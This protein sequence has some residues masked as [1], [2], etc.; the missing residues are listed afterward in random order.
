MPSVRPGGPLSVL[1]LYTQVDAVLKGEAID[2]ISDQETA[3]V[4][5][6]ISRGLQ[7]L[8]HRVTC[9]GVIDDVA[10]A[11]APFAPEEWVV[12][13][14][15]ESL[16]GDSALEQTV[17]PILEAHGFRYT[18]A[19]GQAIAACLNKVGTKEKLLAAG[20]HTP[21][22]ALLSSPDETCHV[23]FPA[24][25]KPSQEDA[26]VGIT[27]D[28]VVR[29]REGLR[30]QVAYIVER[31]RQPALVEEFIPGREFNAAIW[32]NDQPEALPLSEISYADIPD[33]LQRLLTYDSKWV[34]DSYAYSHTPGICPAPVSAELGERIVQTAL[35]AYRL[36]GCRGYARVDMRERDGVPFVLEVNPNP[37]LSS[38]GGFVRAAGVAGYD[39]AHMAERILG[40]ALELERLR[41]PNR[42]PAT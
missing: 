38:E 36:M 5:Q 16:G 23:P 13:N 12:F 30:R 20:I 9:V 33:P 31:Y 17:P 19:T 24:L 39:Q 27:L 8:G 42:R 6:E 10:G 22:Y 40:F 32:G 1:V 21:R 25:V 26:S 15:C 2:L 11:I 18:G 35:T 41:S 7:G 37:S 28:S 14:L 4:A 29:D 34:E 3:R